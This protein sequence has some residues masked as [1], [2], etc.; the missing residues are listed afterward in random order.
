D[1]VEIRLGRLLL[2]Q[3]FVRLR[4]EDQRRLRRG[5]RRGLPRVEV[6]PAE[7]GRGRSRCRKELTTVERR[8][9]AELLGDAGDYRTAVLLAAMTRTITTISVC[10]RSTAIFIVMPPA[11]KLR[12]MT[13]D[14]PY[15]Q[16]AHAYG[17]AV[18]RAAHTATARKSTCAP[19][20][21]VEGSESRKD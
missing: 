18:R 15:S 3:R 8:R 2:N 16:N 19:T 1:L 12:K 11:K 13:C 17:A 14:A 10:S 9:H 4:L 20:N 21:N 6:T 5:A 7:T